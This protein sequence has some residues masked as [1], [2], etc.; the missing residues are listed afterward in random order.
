MTR[1]PVM[2]TGVGLVNALGDDPDVFFERLCAGE[3]AVTA[4]EHRDVSALPVRIGAELKAFD[5]EKAIGAREARLMDPFTQYGIAAAEDALRDAGLVV[6]QNVAPDRVGAVIGCGIGGAT[7]LEREAAAFALEG[8]DEVSPYLMTQVLTN[9]ATAHLAIRHG[10]TGPTMAIANAC[11]TGANAIGEGLR[12]IQRGDAD[13]MVCG[14][15]E[16]PLYPLG[17]AAFAK[18]RALS[19]RNEEPA[20]ASRPFDSGR[21]G[22][23]LGEGGGIVVL[24]SLAHASARGA[25]PRSVL[26]GYGASTD[27]HHVT[28]PDPEGRGAAASM[29]RALADAGIAPADVDYV[30]AHATGT[31]L[32]DISEAR[33]MREVFGAGQPACSATKGSTAHLLGASAAVEAV[34]CALSTQTDLVPPTR[35]LDRPDPQCD[36]NHVRD[37]ALS[38]P[39]RVA[40]SN[41]F[42]FGGHN[43]T[44]VLAKA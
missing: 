9:M 38:R 22:F 26:L 11:A 31:K 10:I 27:A 4:I 6:G 20:R 1:T 21:D 30:N 12:T 35:N 19:R 24:E 42:G 25:R 23:V 28:M 14:A 13:V 40:I 37:Q 39:T 3:S 29:R 5:P 32:G 44:L 2:V 8:I 36:L 17:I 15:A 34:I 33:A 16:A 41:S 7:T 18:A 43:A